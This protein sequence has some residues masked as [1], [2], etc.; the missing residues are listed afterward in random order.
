ML[1]TFPKSQKILSDEWNNRMFAAKAKIFP[2]HLHPAVLPIVEGKQADFERDDGKIKPLNMKRHSVSVR[3]QIK[4]GRGMTLDQFRKKADEAGEALGKDMWATISAA[5]NEAAVE[6]GNEV[7]IKKGNL[8]KENM[9][10]MLEVRAYNFDESGNPVGT[11][12]CGPE[13]ADEIKRRVEEWKDDKEFHAKAEEIMR[14]KKAE[15]NEREARRR[16]VS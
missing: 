4:E 15:F 14:R 9:L 8:T 7:K 10:Q 6:I 16:L 2:N 11:L 13:F 12:V 1:P 5:I 3:H